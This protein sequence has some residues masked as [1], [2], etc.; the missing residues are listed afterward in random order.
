MSS[1]KETRNGPKYDD[2]LASAAAAVGKPAASAGRKTLADGAT[3]FVLARVQATEKPSLEEALIEPD[4][5]NPCACNTVCTCVPV[6]ECGCDQVCTCDT[7]SGCASYCTCIGNC[8]V[9]VW[10]APCS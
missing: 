4:G 7:V 6:N 1:N 3:G 8:C 9:V 5:G 2:R 10:F